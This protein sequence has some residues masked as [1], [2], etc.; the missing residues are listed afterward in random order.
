[1]KKIPLTQGQV[2]LVDD[3]DYY[4][5]IKNKWCYNSSCGAVRRRKNHESRP[6][7]LAYMHR[8]ILEYYKINTNG[9]HI[10]HVNGIKTDNRK[11]N[12]RTATSSQNAANMF[13]YGSKGIDYRPDKRKWRARIKINYKQIFLGH[14]DSEQEAMQAYN[15]AAR[16]YFG[17][18]ARTND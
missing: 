15:T 4:W 9:L 16:K 12:I 1:M 11:Q 18:F 17:E 3:E 14:F 10:D 6:N 8:E 5:I 13:K 2:A 7:R